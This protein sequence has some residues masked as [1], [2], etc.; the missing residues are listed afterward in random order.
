[1]THAEALWDSVDFSFRG[2]H[3]IA[4]IQNDDM[5]HDDDSHVC[6]ESQSRAALSIYDAF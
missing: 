4:N 6:F 5:L 3:D 2:A 1:M